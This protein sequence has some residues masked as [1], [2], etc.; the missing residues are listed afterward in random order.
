MGRM[1]MYGDVRPVRAMRKV[2]FGQRMKPRS[3][4]SSFWFASALFDRGIP[5]RKRAFVTPTPT[6]DTAP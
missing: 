2:R 6:P 5:S 1:P 3:W 4:P